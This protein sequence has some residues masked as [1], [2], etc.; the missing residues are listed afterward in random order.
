MSDMKK[1][2]ESIDA[3]QEVEMFS[4]T[5]EKLAAFKELG[6]DQHQWEVF[7]LTWDYRQNEIDDLKEALAGW[8]NGGPA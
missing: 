4:E 7:S 1:L 2:L 3:I 8:D 6:L 5:P